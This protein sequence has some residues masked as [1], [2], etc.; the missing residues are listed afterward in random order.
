MVTGEELSPKLLSAVGGFHVIPTG[1]AF[2]RPRARCP[3]SRL[4]PSQRSWHPVTTPLHSSPDLVEYLYNLPPFLPAEK[5]RS[6]FGA[7]AVTVVMLSV[8][9]MAVRRCIVSGQNHDAQ[10]GKKRADR[11]S[12]QAIYLAANTG[13]AAWGIAAL[14]P[15]LRSGVWQKTSSA[16]A[17]A[18]GYVA[19]GAFGSAQ[20]GYSIW[21]IVTD[22]R[23]AYFRGNK[24]D[25][26]T[27]MLLHHCV[28]VL[29]SMILATCSLG[30][31]VYGPFFCGIVE[32]SSVPLVIMKGLAKGRQ[33]G[34]HTSRLVFAV[35]FLSVRIV[36]WLVIVRLFFTDLMKVLSLSGTKMGIAV[37]IPWGAA[38]PVLMLTLLQLYWGLVIVKGLVTVKDVS[39]KAHR[40]DSTT[41]S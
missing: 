8:A 5:V 6:A 19:L 12:L 41:T 11:R 34:Y 24:L 15:M 17:R 37:L 28:T 20:A 13:L 25:E 23:N 26:G 39:K 4:R 31:R 22:Q 18:E 38:I 16:L 9:R 32:L 3:H 21:S 27:M 30:F 36:A 2:P 14:I 1:F 33:K 7:V 40:L 29:V 10:K 35:T